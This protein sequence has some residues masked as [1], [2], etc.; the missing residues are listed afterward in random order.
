MLSFRV[1]V[2]AWTISEILLGAHSYLRSS[3]GQAGSAATG[4]ILSIEDFGGEFLETSIICRSMPLTADKYCYYSVAVPDSVEYWNFQVFEDNVGFHEAV[5]APLQADTEL[6]INN[7]I[8]FNNA[9][10]AAE[11]GDTVLVPDAKSFTLMGGVLANDI[12]HVTIDFCGSLHFVDDIDNW[13][14]NT[15]PDNTYEYNDQYNPAIEIYNSTNVTLTSSSPTRAKVNV[16]FKKNTVHLVDSKEYFGGIINGNGKKWWDKTIQGKLDHHRPR[17]IHL[18]ECEHMLIENLTLINSPFWTL[19]VEAVNSEVRHIQVLVDRRYQSTYPETDL[20]ETEQ[21]LVNMQ[22][23]LDGFHIPIPI[24]DLPDWIF[25]K[26]NQPQDLNTDGI[27]PLGQNIWV[28]DC[29]IQ[30]ADDS[31][32]VKSSHGGRPPSRLGDCTQNI[33]IENMILTGFGASVGSV[34]GHEFHRCVDNVTFRNISMPGT[35]KGIYV[36]SEW[37]EHDCHNGDSGQITNILYE[38]VRMYQPFWWSVWIGPQQQHQPGTKLNLDC[39][40]SWP[41]EPHCPVAGCVHMENITLRHILIEEPLISPAVIL[42]N[43][44]N[45]IKNLVIDDLQVKESKTK[46]WHGKWPFHQ[47]SYP[48]HGRMKCMNAEGFYNNSSPEPTCLTPM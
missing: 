30:N 18:I 46:V 33:T 43:E 23:R 15:Y 4:R 7:T 12:H 1:L 28:H 40:L 25:R 10:E 34:S 6:A 5:D 44:T 27:D 32:A 42:G 41:L 20:L 45:P 22:R 35:G 48:W 29:I 13:P 8:A 36:K 17:L 37:G 3:N 19:T 2:F 16:N 21:V 9:L 14:Y 24:D 39:A 26:F 11:P 47:K 38:D 31:V